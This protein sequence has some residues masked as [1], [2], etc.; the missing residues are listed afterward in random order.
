MS[1]CIGILRGM[2]FCLLFS[3]SIKNIFRMEEKRLSTENVS[4]SLIGQ[5]ATGGLPFVLK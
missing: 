4:V 2:D 3:E 1:L 5:S